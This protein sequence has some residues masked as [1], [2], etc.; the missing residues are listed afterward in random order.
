[1]HKGTDPWIQA[2][3]QA[4]Q[5]RAAGPQFGV[6]KALF[7]H[8][9]PL[10]SLMPWPEWVLKRPLARAPCGPGMTSTLGEA[11]QGWGRAGS[12]HR[13]CRD[14]LGFPG[15]SDGKESTCN[16]GDQ[17]SIPGS[18]R[19]PGERNDYPLQYP[20][21]ENSMDRGAWQATVHGVTKSRTRLSD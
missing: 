9:L 21:L 4:T 10:L 1:M 13:L 18:E 5:C 15:G 20:C 2:R 11:G 12:C 16:A 14:S 8:F 6:S 17:G 3:C 7:C 19:S